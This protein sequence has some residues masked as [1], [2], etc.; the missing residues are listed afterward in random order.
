MARMGNERKRDKREKMMGRKKRWNTEPRK[1]GKKKK[2]GGN[3]PEAI[4]LP[5]IHVPV[6][7]GCGDNVERVSVQQGGEGPR[8]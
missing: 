2:E 4:A 5:R 8:L 1:R 3:P 7:V 6:R